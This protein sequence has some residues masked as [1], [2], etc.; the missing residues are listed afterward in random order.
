MSS[1]FVLEKKKIQEI[2]DLSLFY[3]SSGNDCITPIKI[4]A[5]V[6]TEFW[7]VDRGYFHPGHSDTRLYGFDAPAD[8]QAPLLND[9]DYTLIDIRHSGPVSWERYQKDIEPCVLTEIYMHKPSKKQISIHRRR[10]YGF[11]AFRKEINKLGVFFYRGDSWGEGGSGNLWLESSHINEICEKLVDGGLIV[12]DGCNHG[13][14]ASKSRIYGELWK[15]LG[16]SE[17]KLDA[18][19]EL[20]CSMKKFQDRCGRTFICIGYA[21][22]RYGSTMIWQVRKNLP[23]RIFQLSDR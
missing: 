11:S 22:Y 18:P 7:F 17:E 1:E 16:R 8:K 5:P 20:V 4:F 13:R 2:E 6:I 21:G 19:N 15:Y 9:S 14:R 3:P 23:G 10:G 12:T